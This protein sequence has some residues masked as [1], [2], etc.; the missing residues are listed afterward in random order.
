M[1]IFNNSLEQALPQ[2][3]PYKLVIE[4]FASP[5]PEGKTV[6]KAI[7]LG[8]DGFRADGLVNI[9]DMDNSAIMYIKE[10][11]G[12]YHSFSGG[13]PNTETIQATSTVPAWMAMLTGGWGVTYN[14]VTDN[15]QM[16]DPN[17]D[18]FL[19]KLNKEGKA[20]S[21]TTSWREHTSLSYR[22]DILDAIR[23]HRSAEYTHQIDD[24]ATY[25]QILKYVAKPKGAQKTVTEDPDVIFFTFEH[26][27]HAGHHSGY[28]NTNPEYVAACQEA[29]TWGYDIVKTIEA[30]ATFAEEDWLILITSD[31]G[32]ID[33]DHGGQTP[34]E[35]RTWITSNHPIE[36][37]E[38]NLHFAL[39][40]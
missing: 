5:L 30:R 36:M 14:G 8:Y 27:D 15:G 16:K 10:Q 17:I 22:P 13:I 34:E 31:H 40:K 12:L 29:D 3:L 28:G 7:L 32:G 26:T 37:S 23:N 25:Y 1:D 33:H 19:S 6:K 4:H 35:R 9:M 38:E 24:V 11:G 2:T 39:T 20:I 18:T 21:F